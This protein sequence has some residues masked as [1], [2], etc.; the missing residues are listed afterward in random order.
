MPNLNGTGPR[1]KG[2]RT[3]RGRGRC[4]AAGSNHPLLGIGQDGRPCG[5]N[6]GRCCDGLGL[7]SN[8]KA[9]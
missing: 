2:S 1:G 5:C 3:G 9:D 4:C 8:K 6:Q 7:R